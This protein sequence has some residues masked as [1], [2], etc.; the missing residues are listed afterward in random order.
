MVPQPDVGGPWRAERVIFLRD[1]AHCRTA[2]APH[3]STADVL[4]EA[5][6]GAEETATLVAAEPRL[7]CPGGVLVGLSRER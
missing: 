5:G 3:R 4:A 1:R 7:L 6:L 2:S